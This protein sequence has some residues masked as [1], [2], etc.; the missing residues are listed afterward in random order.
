[1]G[2]G[3]WRTPGRVFSAAAGGLIKTIQVG[4][5]PESVA[6]TP[7]G[8]NEGPAASP[9]AGP[10]RRSQRVAAPFLPRLA[11]RPYCTASVTT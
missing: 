9:A 4:S 10:S 7:D 11:P 2:A 8:H 1:M 5:L 3:R 6:V